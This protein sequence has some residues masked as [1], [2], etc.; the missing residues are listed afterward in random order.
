MYISPCKANSWSEMLENAKKNGETVVSKFEEKLKENDVQGTVDFSVRS[1]PG[2][3]IMEQADK[4]N[5]SLIVMGTRGFGLVR[6]TILGS[7]SHHV[8]HH[9]KIP[10][11]VVPP[12]TQSWFF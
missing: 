11:T 7:V 8:V 5:A 12:E 10:V 2:E 4:A 6:R 3:Y 1:K 9:A